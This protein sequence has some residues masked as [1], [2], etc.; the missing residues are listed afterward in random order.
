MDGYRSIHGLREQVK[1][2]SDNKLEAVK[3]CY[4]VHKGVYITNL[5]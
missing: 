5:H 4:G 1:E 2:I 3:V